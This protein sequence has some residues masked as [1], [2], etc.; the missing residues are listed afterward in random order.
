MQHSPYKSWTNRNNCNLDE[1]FHNNLNLSSWW[2]DDVHRNLH[3]YWT[4][5]FWS[6]FDGVLCDWDWLEVIVTDFDDC[7]L[8]LSMLVRTT[9]SLSR[10]RT[11]RLNLRESST[12]WPATIPTI[13]PPPSTTKASRNCPSSHL[14]SSSRYTP[15]VPYPS[16][17]YSIIGLRSQLPIV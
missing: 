9:G 5:D 2:R 15:H 11:G 8:T 13:P 7:R 12:D 16:H 4:N 14:S 1:K 10:H 3:K 6:Y 17:A